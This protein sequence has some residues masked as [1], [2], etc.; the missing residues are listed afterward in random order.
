MPKT[1]SQKHT[2]RSDSAGQ[3][4]VTSPRKANPMNHPLAFVDP[5]LTGSIVEMRSQNE[6]RL[7][8]AVKQVAPP[9]P[10]HQTPHHHNHAVTTP[11]LCLGTTD[12]TRAGS[13]YQ[14]V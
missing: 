7:R 8:D 2:G 3:K 13:W 14:R 12:P 6:K 5:E 4:R 1:V 9:R 11:S 10:S